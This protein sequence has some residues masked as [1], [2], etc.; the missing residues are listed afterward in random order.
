LKPANI[1]LAADGTL[2][3]TDFGHATRESLPSERP[4]FHGVFTLWYRAPELLLSAPTHTT[5]ADV[6]AGGCIVAEMML[7]RPL[8][9]WTP[10]N[11]VSGP[12]GETHGQWA[13]ICRLRGTP[14]DWPGVESL[15]GYLALEEC[16]AVDLDTVLK[17]AGMTALAADF[18]NLAL[19]LNP[20][21]RP[22]AAELLRHPWF[23][24]APPPTP[25]GS[26]P[27]P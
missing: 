4:L 6:W 9:A 3:V 17:P 14:T 25:A 26:L 15:P 24:T 7:R 19:T 21:K 2:R 8:F 16:A 18:L 22:S 12:M 11:P 13:E 1:L 27:K 5:A 20:S 23:T 10:T